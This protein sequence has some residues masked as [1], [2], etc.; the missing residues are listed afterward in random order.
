MSGGEEGEAAGSCQPACK[1]LAPSVGGD[2][3]ERR[4]GLNLVHA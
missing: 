2:S 1:H 3:Q 4:K